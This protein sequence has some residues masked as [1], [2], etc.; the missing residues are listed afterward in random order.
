[1]S[2]LCVGSDPTPLLD[3]LPEA[4]L[5][6]DDG[7][8][9][10]TVSIRAKRFDV[11]K[12]SLNPLKDMDEHKAMSFI[13]VLDGAFPEGENTLTRRYSNH[14]MLKR[15]L[16]KPGKLADLIVPT[17]DPYERDANEKIERLLLSDTLRPVLNSSLSF[18]FGRRTIARLN[19][20]E[21]GDFNCFVLGNFLMAQY[22]GPI[23]VADFGFYATAAHKRLI[24]QDR[25]FAGLR[26]I[27]DVPKLRNDLLMIPTKIA[28]K[29]TPDDAAILAV[30]AGHLPGTEGASTFI[31]KSIR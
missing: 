16:D 27:E 17:K 9:T 4:C 19:R 24:R 2:I 15:L 30:F 20:A 14:V 8:L 6:I 10:D 7:E 31:Q 1:M 25:L 23:V 21:I 29:C 26:S 22:A 13:A 18:T 12:H 3:H 28:R 11:S 5:I